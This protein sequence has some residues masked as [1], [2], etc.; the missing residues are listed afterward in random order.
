MRL[1]VLESIS[2]RGWPMKSTA[3]LS[4]V[5]ITQNRGKWAPQYLG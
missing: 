5:E 1:T 3:Y 2:N 4:A